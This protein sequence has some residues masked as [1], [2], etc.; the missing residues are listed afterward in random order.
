MKPR[1]W[2]SPALG[3]VTVTLPALLGCALVN[4]PRADYVAERRA[5][6]AREHIVLTPDL[7]GR[8]QPLDRA[9][10][11]AELDEARRYAGGEDRFDAQLG[12]LYLTA[13]AYQQ[14]QECLEAYERLHPGPD[15]EARFGLGTCALMLGRTD[16]GVQLLEQY[17]ADVLESVGAPRQPGGTVYSRALLAGRAPR[18]TPGTALTLALGLNQVGYVLADADVPALRTTA[19]QLTIAANRLE[20]LMPMIMDSVGW[21]HYRCGHTEEALFWMQK[22]W[23][24]YGGHWT[25]PPGPGAWHRAPGSALVSVYEPDIPYHLGMVYLAAGHDIEGDRM[26]RV[27]LSLDPAHPG[28]RQALDKARQQRWR[29]P[30]PTRV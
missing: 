3:A 8:L 1:P 27:A 4:A 25:P 13:G 18:Q 12:E 24:H 16:D 15:R 21:A 11:V 23:R 5:A 2:R 7:L 29:L 9:R 26:L 17:L 14:A 10:G 6:Q 20:P 28:A 22:A 30:P 19:L